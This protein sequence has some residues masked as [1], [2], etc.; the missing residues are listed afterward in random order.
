[1]ILASL[2]IS[3]KISALVLD[4][5]FPYFVNVKAF[6]DD[7]ARI[8]HRTMCP[9]S[10]QGKTCGTSPLERSLRRTKVIVVLCCDF[11]CKNGVSLSLL[12]HRCK[13]EQ[14]LT[15]KR[16]VVAETSWLPLAFSDSPSSVNRLCAHLFWHSSHPRI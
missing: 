5:L 6:L 9:S 10:T 16:S 11:R 4:R 3:H 13:G 14:K 7:T 8:T 1:M 15:K 12:R 2:A